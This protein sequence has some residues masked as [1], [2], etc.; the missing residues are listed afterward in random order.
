MELAGSTEIY[1]IISRLPLDLKRMELLRDI[2]FEADLLKRSRFMEKKSINIDSFLKLVETLNV[3]KY[4]ITST[5]NGK[6][7]VMYIEEGKIVSTA[8]GDPISGK[9]VVG[10]RALA[11]FI[12]KLL[13]EELSVRIFSI[14]EEKVEEEAKTKELPKEET[15]PIKR[16]VLRRIRELAQITVKQRTVVEREISIAEK[17]ELDEEKL[18][19]LKNK[20]EDILSDILSYH[21]YKLTELKV[22]VKD[23]DI[24][25]DVGMKK[26]KLFGATDP[27]V[28]EKKM[29]KETEILLSMLD[30]SDKKF[31]LTVHKK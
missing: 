13:V 15:M 5:V 17:K 11:H 25:I 23:S 10:L 14:G 24:Y 8:L 29:F 22:E 18:K 16:P 31:R 19:E 27:K 26:K 6:R 12:S 20:L 2:T 3:G 7:F 28:L 21:G 4:L 1:E 30:L 9:R